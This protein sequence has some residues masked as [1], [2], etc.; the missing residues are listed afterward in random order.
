[1]RPGRRHLAESLLPLQRVSPLPQHWEDL[2]YKNYIYS[3]SLPI[4][5]LA[6]LVLEVFGFSDLHLESTTMLLL[7]RPT[8]RHP[9]PY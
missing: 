3:D 2:S 6:S 8:Q 1:M 5:S 7:S 4:L 9:E